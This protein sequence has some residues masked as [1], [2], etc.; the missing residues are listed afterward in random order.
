MVHESPEREVTTD[1]IGEYLM[2][3]LRD[4][5]KVA[6]VRFAS[7]YRDFKD[8]PDFVKAL[9]E[10]LIHREGGAPAPQ[11]PRPPVAPA[12][13]TPLFPGDEPPRVKRK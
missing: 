10:V 13:E 4:L 9:E 5:D 2:E 1:A 12:V 3:R 7:V 8:L 11:A 6:F